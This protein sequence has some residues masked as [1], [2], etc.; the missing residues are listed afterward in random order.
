MRKLVVSSLVTAD[1]IHG[2]PQVWAGEYSDEEA[3]TEWLA[4]LRKS[5]AFLMGRNTYELFAQ[6]WGTPQGPYLERLYEMPKYVFSSTL[7]AA[8]WNNTKI[9][10][11]DPVP[12]VR[13]LKE[14]GDGD[15]MVYSY[16][17]FSQTLL[18]H[19]LVDELR[20]TVNPVML[21]SG[22]PLFRPGTRTNLRLQSV[23]QRGNGAIAVTYVPV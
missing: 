23:T 22:T 14:Q 18:E 1:G 9:V 3:A 11:G 20:F 7:A 12:A 8:D 13:E 6:M 4:A 21:G 16:S 10:S 2:D 19:G 15:L 5:D 17:Q